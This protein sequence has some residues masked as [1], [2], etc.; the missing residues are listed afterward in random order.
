MEDFVERCCGDRWQARTSRVEPDEDSYEKGMHIPVSVLN[1]CGDSFIAAD[2]KREKTS[3]CFFTDTGLMALVCRH[4]CVL[5]IGNLMS[6]GEKQH[7][8]LALLD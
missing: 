8:A 6:A 4:D 7:Y 1:G 5:W 2:E 3:T